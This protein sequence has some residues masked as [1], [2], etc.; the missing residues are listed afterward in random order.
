[1]VTGRVIAHGANLQPVAEVFVYGQSNTRAR[2][3]A[4]VDTGFT[5]HLTLPVNAIT[6]LNLEFAFK[7]KLTMA[8]DEP[9]NIDVYT[10]SIDWD[11]RTRQVEVHSAEGDP[12][13]G[14]AMLRD[15]DL[16]I[17]AIPDGSVSI[18]PLS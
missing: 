11:G 17:R 18:E 9:I 15:H 1:M 12:L 6:T 8:N 3:Q 10:A 13:I 7:E 2:V 5:Q 4:V 14:M 16:H